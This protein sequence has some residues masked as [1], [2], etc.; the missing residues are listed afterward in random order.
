MPRLRI[1]DRCGS[2]IAPNAK[3]HA[4]RERRHQ[5]RVCAL[6]ARFRMLQADVVATQRIPARLRRELG[7][8]DVMLWDAERP[9][10]HARWTTDNRLLLGGCDWPPVPSVSARRR[11]AMVRQASGSTFEPALCGSRARGHRFRVGRV[12]RHDA[13]RSAVCRTASRLPE[14]M[15]A[16]RYGATA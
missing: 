10:H 11:Y 12:V 16:L 7:L 14:V 9:Y 4:I 8:G 6:A 5:H 1:A 2:V 13:R 3:V 15:F